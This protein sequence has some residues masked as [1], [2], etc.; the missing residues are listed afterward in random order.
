MS[1]RPYYSD[2]S[3]LLQGQNVV[4]ILEEN[5]RFSIELTCKLNDLWRMDVFGLLLL[6]HARK[7][8]LKQACLEFGAQDSRYSFIDNFYRQFASCNHLGDLLEVI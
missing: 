7:G 5:D 6:R 1:H 8:S 2:I 3:V 4:V